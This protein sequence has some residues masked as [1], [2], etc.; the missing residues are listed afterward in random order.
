MDKRIT[1]LSKC[2][3]ERLDQIQPMPSLS[4]PIGYTYP[5][6]KELELPPGEDRLALEQ[7]AEG[8]F[9]QRIFFDKIHLCPSCE[10]YH[11]NFRETCPAC[12]SS[13]VSIIDIIHHLKCAYSG[14]EKEFRDGTR[15]VCPKCARTLR[16]IGV[17]Y[18]KPNRNFLCASCSNIFMEPNIS[19]VCIHC[20]S[21]TP[22]HLLE[23][24]ILNSYRV[25]PKGMHAVERG[26]INDPLGTELYV[27]ETGT[28]TF[29]FLSHQLKHE[30]S[31][32]YRYKRHFSVMALALQV[33]PE[34]EP[35]FGRNGWR[36]FHKLISDTVIGTLRDCDLTAPWED[37]KFI[38]LLPDTPE[39]NAVIVTDRLAE[40]LN[41]LAHERYDGMARIAAAVTGSPEERL[42]VDGLLKLLIGRLGA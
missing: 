33:S 4:S 5:D 27:R 6:A 42:D 2:V 17:D 10:H 19:C 1:F 3:Q 29:D 21:I 38:M 9:M 20:S 32:W 23:V 12:N 39:Q 35:R 41:N 40:R 8:G 7:L 22:V 18:E 25:T 11:L 36:Q 16:H 13:D 26:T 37:E 31:R 15:L 30:L 34:F 24:A 14:P 28:Y